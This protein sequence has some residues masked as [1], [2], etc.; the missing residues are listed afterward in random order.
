[1]LPH[2]IIASLS[3]IA[4][5]LL[6]GAVP[7]ID[8]VPIGAERQFDVVL[9]GVHPG[10]VLLAAQILLLALRWRHRSRGFRRDLGPGE[11]LEAGPLL[12]QPGPS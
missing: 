4:L 3:P 5:L 6:A 9:T 8:A 12:P 10:L 11:R 7:L 1:M 2:A